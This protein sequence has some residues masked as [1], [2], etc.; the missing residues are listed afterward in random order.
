MLRCLHAYCGFYFAIRFGNWLLRNSC[1]KI[2]TE[3]FFAYS[4]DKY[5]V[6]GINALTDSYTY[7]KEILEIFRNGQWTVCVKASQPFHNLAL[8]EAHEWIVNRKLKQV[9]TRPCH[10]RMVELADCMAHLDGVISGLETRV[11]KFHKNSDYHKKKKQCTSKIAQF[12]QRKHLQI[13]IM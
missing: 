9:T 12:N 2:L 7:P 13:L 8:D 6:V 3:L 4:R 1:L 5:E 10:F 11:F